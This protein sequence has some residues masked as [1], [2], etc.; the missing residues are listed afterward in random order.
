[1]GFRERRRFA[2]TVVAAMRKAGLEPDTGM[3]EY[4]AEQFEITNAPRVG[5]RAADE[6]VILRE[7][8]R[9]VALV[10]GEEVT[11]TPLRDPAGVGNGVHIHL[12]FLDADG[13]PA[14]YG[15]QARHG[16]S[17]HAA[18]F[19]AGVLKY[20]DSFVALTAA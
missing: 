6:A 11:F 14:T 17:V 12:S 5:G 13:K 4:G 1:A 20:L 18:R 16:L 2:E 8:V 7:V 10:T 3:E 19:I 9:A 15:P